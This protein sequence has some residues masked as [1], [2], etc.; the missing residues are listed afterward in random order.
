MLTS[1]WRRAIRHR[2]QAILEGRAQARE[3]LPLDRVTMVLLGGRRVIALAPNA[4][5]NCRATACGALVRQNRPRARVGRHAA[6]ALR[7]RL[8]V[9]DFRNAPGDEISAGYVASR[10]GVG[11]RRRMH[12]C[13]DH[14]ASD[15]VTPA[16]AGDRDSE[17]VVRARIT[18]ECFAALASST[19]PE[20][21]KQLL[22]RVIAA[23]LGVAGA[24]AR[25]YR[26]RGVPLE[27]LLQVARMALVVACQSFEPARGHDFLTYAV[28]TIKGSV[29]KYFRDQ[30]WMVRP[31]RGIR[32]LQSRILRLN[33]HYDEHDV[34]A[35]AE[36]VGEPVEA[37]R[38]AL[39]ARGCFQPDSIDAPV[40]DGTYRVADHLTAG[41]E[42]AFDGVEERMSAG[43]ALRSLDDRSKQL[44]YLRFYQEWSQQQ[45][46][47]EFGTSQVQVSR[48]LSR[49]LAR[50]RRL[51]NAEDELTG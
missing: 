34:T 38:E 48:E 11:N 19:L 5:C 12:E 23:N 1:G 3:F 36:A 2:G 29:L 20:E 47:D 44:L 46:A 6:V 25:R 35:L 27:D 18:E 9:P 13:N 8:W 51:I 21:Q 43:A 22:D 40:G 16:A 24:I 30:G 31:P 32:E 4:C 15:A 33:P 41:G 28:P 17:R 26:D 14:A 37:V 7:G 39:A 10:D 50:V 45:L 49:I 42:E